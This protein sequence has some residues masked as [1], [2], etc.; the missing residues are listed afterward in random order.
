MKLLPHAVRKAELLEQDTSSIAGELKQE[1]IVNG[2]SE[3]TGDHDEK[4]AEEIAD[5]NGN[6]EETQDEDKVNGEAF[7]EDVDG[8]EKAE[9]TEE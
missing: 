1:K 5:G 3:K 9:E 8:G 7:K 2:A 6:S 4:S